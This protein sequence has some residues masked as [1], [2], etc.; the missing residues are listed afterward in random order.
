MTSI[1]EYRALVT[2]QRELIE[3]LMH[4]IR[5]MRNSVQVIPT[6]VYTP[7]YQTPGTQGVQS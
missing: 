4:Q 3:L 1:E 6:P 5:E 2:Q 7:P